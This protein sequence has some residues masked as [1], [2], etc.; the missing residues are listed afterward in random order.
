MARRME[1]GEP[2]RS[3]DPELQAGRDRA[4]ELLARYNALAAT[5]HAVRDAL[6]REL[7]ADVGEGAVVLAPLRCD[8][9]DR[10]SIGPRTFVNFECL[11][12]D[13][14]PIRIGADCQL[15]PRVQLLTATH[16]VDAAE[17]RS[18]W[19][20]ARPVTLGDDVWLGAGAIVLPGVS[21]GDRTVVGAGAVVTRDLP[22]GVVAA[23][24]P[25]Q[26][27]RELA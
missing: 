9:G 11:L 10:I 3:D 5:D 22:A 2:F 14:A 4:Q 25:A 7:L 12:L 1:R 6:L 13:G 20:L 24:N 18:G 19:E 8:Y 27:V 26:V 23:G 17:R 16:P 21:I 15:A